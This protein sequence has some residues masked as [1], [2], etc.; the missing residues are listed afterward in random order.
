MH[1]SLSIYLSIYLSMYIY[2]LR[3]SGAPATPLPHHLASDA[4]LTR[5]SSLFDKQALSNKSEACSVEN[6]L[7]IK[8]RSRIKSLFE[9][10]RKTL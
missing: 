2:L 8:T 5:I 3:H 10:N 7:Q 1:I 9:P 4:R 6:R